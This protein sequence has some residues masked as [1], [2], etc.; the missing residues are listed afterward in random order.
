MECTICF[1]AITED[2]GVVKMACKHS[3]HFCCLATWFST[4]FVN[5]Q[6]ESCPCCRKEAGEKEGLPK[7]GEND[8]NR[9]FGDLLWTEDSATEVENIFLNMTNQ[10]QRNLSIQGEVENM[11]SRGSQRDLTTSDLATVERLMEMIRQEE[12]IEG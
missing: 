11:L 8:A 7:R 10:L 3:F 9:S 1:E 2:T 5:T 4:Q 6:K 12:I